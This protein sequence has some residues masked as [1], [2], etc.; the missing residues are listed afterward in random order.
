MS[1]L[2]SRIT[3][4]RSVVDS[5]KM[6]LVGGCFDVLHYGHIMFLQ[7][8]HAKGEVLVVA[9]ESDW[10]IKTKKKRNPIHTQDMRKK[11]LMALRSVD[12]VINLPPMKQDHD[13]EE[14]VWALKPHVIAVTS[15]DPHMAHKK[16]FAHAIGARVVSVI[17]RIPRYSSTAII[18]R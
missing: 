13:Y 17:K 3:A 8:A 12:A 10:F 9:L 14:L 7:K 15:P 11:I 16:K 6:V 18:S 5:K 1:I 4:V 2:A